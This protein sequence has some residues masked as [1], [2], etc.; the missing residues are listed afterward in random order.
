MDNCSDGRIRVDGDL[1]TAF[2]EKQLVEYRRRDVGF[3]FQFY[4]LIPT[5]TALENV[6]LASQLTD[7][8][9]DPARML[10]KVGLGERMNN[11]PSQLSGGEQQR[12]SIA[13]ALA[14]NPKL[15]LC[16]EPTGALDY[17]TGKQILK[18]L[19]ETCHETGMTIVV[20]T[21]NQALAPMADRIITMRSGRVT[22]IAV[23]DTPLPVDSIEW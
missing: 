5:L 23:N 1:I 13:R 2:D 22:Q 6:E 12:T 10:T 4:N 16:D 7:N 18:L 21:H 20:I 19:Q 14:K 11:F 17:V 3:V 15:L 8:G 9:V